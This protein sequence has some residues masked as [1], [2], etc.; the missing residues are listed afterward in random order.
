MVSLTETTPEQP[1]Q[2][3]STTQ[4]SGVSESG[5]KPAETITAPPPPPPTTTTTTTTTTATITKISD[6]AATTSPALNNTGAAITRKPPISHD[7]DGTN[8]LDFT[9][10]VDTT[11]LH[12]LPSPATIRKID[13]HLVLDRNGK[14]HTFRSLYTGR[15]VARRVLVIFVRHFYCGN[16]QQYLSLLAKALPPQLLLGLPIPTFIVVIGCGDP[17]LIDMYISETNC[18]F[19]VY[20]DPTRKLYE[21]L[22]MIRSLAMGQR[23]AYMQTHIIKS[24]VTSV[25][26]GLKQLKSGL[27]L[28]GGDQRQIGGEFLFEPIEEVPSPVLE[29]K[30]GILGASSGEKE[31]RGGGG[32]GGEEPDKLGIK[33]R[34]SETPSIDG[35]NMELGGDG[36]DGVDKVVTWCHRMR[37]TRDHA[38]LP[39]LMEV[40][41]IEPGLVNLEEAGLGDVSKGGGAADKEKE[42]RERALK[43]RKGTGFSVVGKRMSGVF[44]GGGEK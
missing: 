32:G 23:P 34:D 38:E 8:P 31:G 27:A 22:R 1:A 30:G 44:G 2:A 41:G 14:S 21:E 29:K 18:P 16:C 17:G 5:A 24:S 9:G 28:K 10:S 13:R 43:E 33:H 26:Q 25:V 15:H 11:N 42:R 19:P 6:V 39:E 7:E 35:K 20:S 12:A 4:P 3:T 36:F 37:N 40:L